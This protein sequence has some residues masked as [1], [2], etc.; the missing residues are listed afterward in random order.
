MNELNCDSCGFIIEKGQY[1][2]EVKLDD[3]TLK[4]SHGGK[5]LSVFGKMIKRIPIK[6]PDW[7]VRDIPNPAGDKLMMKELSDR[8]DKLSK[9]THEMA[10]KYMMDLQL[11]VV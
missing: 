8:A 6:D 11:F 10:L 5:C 1:A 9:Q 4:H 2:Y 7:W 3:G